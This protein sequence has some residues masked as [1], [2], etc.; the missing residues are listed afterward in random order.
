[1]TCNSEVGCVL[2]KCPD[3][4]SFFTNSRRTNA[5]EELAA[6]CVGCWEDRCDCSAPGQFLKTIVESQFFVSR[7]DPFEVLV[8]Y[9]LP[10]D[11]HHN[12][13][14]LSYCRVLAA[15]TTTV[16]GRLE[17]PKKNAILTSTTTSG[18]TTLAQFLLQYFWRKMNIFCSQL[19]VW[20]RKNC[21]QTLNIPI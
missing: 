2:L 13:W 8:C 5:R 21:G 7:N 1:M 4:T 11:F 9:I 16:I 19:K 6:N 12:E 15:F 14:L 3:G 17:E 10:K 18:V 20:C